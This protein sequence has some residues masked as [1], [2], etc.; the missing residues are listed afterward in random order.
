MLQKIIISNIKIFTNHGCMV[1]EGKIGS[2]YTVDLEVHADM[3]KSAQSDDLVDTVDYVHLNQI[4]QSEMAVRAKLLETVAQRIL[5]RI[6]EELK[7]VEF[8]EVC[9]SKINPPMG[10]NV[11]K[12]SVIFNRNYSKSQ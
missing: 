11:E 5:N 2:E 10:G 1:E 3:L 12:V 4:I 6:G 9:I 8:A 7:R